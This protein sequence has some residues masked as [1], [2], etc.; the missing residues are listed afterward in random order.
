MECLPVLRTSVGLRVAAS[1]LP[2][3][4]LIRS[5][6]CLKLLKRK[7]TFSAAQNQMKVLKNSG[8]TM[9]FRPIMVFGRI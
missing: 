2:K 9:A 5:C 7:I 3:P 8:Q 4:N 6:K 1:L